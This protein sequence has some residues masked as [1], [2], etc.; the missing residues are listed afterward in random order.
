MDHYQQ[1]VR[2]LLICAHIIGSF[3]C[4]WRNKIVDGQF[5]VGYS[6]TDILM[7]PL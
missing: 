1:K 5:N 4:G 7:S 3:C 2:K 6:I